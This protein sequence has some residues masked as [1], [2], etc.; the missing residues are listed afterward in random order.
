MKYALVGTGRM[1][2][3]IE[4]EADRRGHRKVGELDVEGGPFLVGPRFT[5][6]AIGSPDAAFEFTIGAAAES[7]VVALLG[8]GLPV[9]PFFS[10]GFESG[11]LS[12]WS[13]K[14]P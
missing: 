9:V 13:T 11:D 12:A 4:R 8:A 6:A 3:A 14:V 7:N 5:A 1:G 2:R 10:D